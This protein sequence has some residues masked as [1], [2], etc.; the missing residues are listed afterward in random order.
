MR[1][2]S[3][4]TEKGETMKIKKMVCDICGDEIPKKVRHSSL[5]RYKVKVRHVHQYSDWGETDIP[6]SERIDLC[7]TCFEN[8][9]RGIG[10]RDD[11]ID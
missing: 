2:I 7:P 10:V 11:E 6:S 3:V 4:L 9:C 5:E 8:L 1:E